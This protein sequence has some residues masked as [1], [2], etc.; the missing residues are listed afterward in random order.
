M[1][2]QKYLPNSMFPLQYYLAGVDKSVHIFP[3]G[4]SRNVNTIA[5]LEFELAYFDVTIRH[6]ATTPRVFHPY[7]LLLLTLNHIIVCKQMIIIK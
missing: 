7:R 4:I 3:R 2:D 5:Q 1:G 6:L